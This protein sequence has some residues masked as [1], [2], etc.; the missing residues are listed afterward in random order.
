MIFSHLDSPLVHV[1]GDGLRAQIE[2]ARDPERNDHVWIS[3]DAGMPERITISVN[4]FSLR[5]QDTGFDGRVRVGIVRAEW[6]SLPP[7]GVQECA[8]FDYRD[9]ES[10]ENVFYES[11]DREALGKMILEMCA[12][13]CRLE[14][15]GTP[16]RRRQNG[17]HQIH[18][19]RASCAVAEDIFKRDGAL[20]FYFDAGRESRM[21]FFK[22]CG[23]T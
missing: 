5:N 22:F 4:I 7:R 2:D 11:Y 12:Q 6:E 10:R 21:L 23:Q 9:W 17:V 1:M 8:E 13:S 15:W 3:L 16:Y 14:A 19:R 18:S 20:K